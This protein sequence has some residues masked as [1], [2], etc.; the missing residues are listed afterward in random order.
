MGKLASKYKMDQGAKYCKFRF[1]AQI[2]FL[3]IALKSHI[4]CVKISRQVRDLLISVK[5]RETSPFPDGSFF[6]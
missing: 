2:L 3:R 4:C 5:G 6:M 1:F